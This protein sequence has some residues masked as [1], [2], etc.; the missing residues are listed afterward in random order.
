MKEGKIVKSADLYFELKDQLSNAL[1]DETKHFLADLHRHGMYYARFTKPGRY[2]TNHEIAASLDRL[3][4]IEATVAYPLLLRVFDAAHQGSLTHA[5]LLEVLEILESFLI[6]RSV[7]GY[8]SNQLRKILPPI[9]D[10]VGGPSESFVAGIRE[11][12]G[13]NDALMTRPFTTP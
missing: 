7:C 5:Q 8:P 3:L 6:R 12:L 2:E 10:A 4:V 11:Q 1:P 9:F 13:E